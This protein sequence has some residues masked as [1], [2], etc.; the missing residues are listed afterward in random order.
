MN[1]SHDESLHVPP[2]LQTLT[3]AFRIFFE[4]ILII[5]QHLQAI[6]F[7]QPNARHQNLPQSNNIFGANISGMFGGGGGY[8]WQ[9]S[10]AAEGSSLKGLSTPA[11]LGLGGGGNDGAGGLPHQQDGYFS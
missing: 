4:E 9:K 11:L 1:S 5:F 7:D 6:I 3:Y 10:F 2:A 8:H